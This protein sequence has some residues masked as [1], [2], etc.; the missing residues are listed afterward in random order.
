M[1]YYIIQTFSAL[2]I[3]FSVGL[4]VHSIWQLIKIEIK[5]QILEHEQKKFKK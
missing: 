3:L 1:T 5:I 2:V 4:I